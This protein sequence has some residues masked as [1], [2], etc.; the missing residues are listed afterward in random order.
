MEVGWR[1]R[2]AW[3][4]EPMKTGQ[5]LRGRSSKEGPFGCSSWDAL[6]VT[7]GVTVEWLV[8]PA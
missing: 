3:G 8:H 2:S 1:T 7:R 4:P 6:T 5:E